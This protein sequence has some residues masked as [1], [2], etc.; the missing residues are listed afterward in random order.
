MRFSAAARESCSGSTLTSSSRRAFALLR[1]ACRS[2]FLESERSSPPT[3][4]RCSWRSSALD[5]PCSSQLVW[6][7]LDWSS[8]LPWPRKPAGNP[9]SRRAASNSDRFRDSLRMPPLCLAVCG[10][11]VCLQG[12]SCLLTMRC[13]VALG[14]ASMVHPSSRGAGRSIRA[15]RALVASFRAFPYRS[16]PRVD[17]LENRSTTDRRDAR[18]SFPWGHTNS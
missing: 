9:S 1:W 3:V 16:Q 10:G 15:P 7:S 12:F 11:F 17:S 13:L 4:R 5:R 6:F 8:R 2:L 18:R 14:L